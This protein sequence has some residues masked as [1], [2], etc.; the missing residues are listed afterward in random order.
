MG[1]TQKEYDEMD[2]EQQSATT[3]LEVSR[4]NRLAVLQALNDQNAKIAT[5]EGEL[6]LIARKIEAVME[7]LAK[8]KQQRVQDLVARVGTGPTAS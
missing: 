3:K 8:L 1:P 2:R 7:E 4:K 5:L 6:V